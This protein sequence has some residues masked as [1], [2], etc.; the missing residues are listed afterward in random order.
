MFRVC[1][2]NVIIIPWNLCR[3]R[4]VSSMPD[5]HTDRVTKTQVYLVTQCQGE[6]QLWKGFKLSKLS[7]KRWWGRIKKKK[8][9]E[10]MRWKRW[11][12]EQE[13]TNSWTAWRWERLGPKRKKKCKDPEV[14]PQQGGSGWTLEAV[15]NLKRETNKHILLLISVTSYDQSWHLYCHIHPYWL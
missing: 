5:K 6:G 7:I 14:G 15:R 4:A 11:R 2:M 3:D 10:M 8:K 9:R 1:C 12:A 13:L